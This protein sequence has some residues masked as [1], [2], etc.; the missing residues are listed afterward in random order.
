MSS[1]TEAAEKDRLAKTR[2]IRLLQFVAMVKS[3]ISKRGQHPKPHGVVRAS[4]EVLD[5]IP[6]RYKVG[7]FAKP[8]R[9]DAL[10][11]FS[12]GPQTE[13]REAGPQGMAIKLIGVPGEKI[14]EA[15][16]TAATH[17][18]I[19]IDGP[20]FFVRDTD[21]YVRLF[22]ELVRNLGGKPKEWLA[23][24]E[25]AHP[26]DIAV[27]ENYHNR[28]VD[29]P[30]AR[31]FWS[32]VPYAFGR[33]DTT[34]C[35]YQAVPDPQNMAAPIPPQYRDK[36]YLRRAM[37]DQLTTSARSASFDFFVQL[38]TDATPEVID[39]PTVEWDTPVQRVATIT[40]P[41]QD[42]DRP[43]QVRFGENLSYTPWHALPEH[44]PVGQ[45]NEIRRT[46]YAATSRLR[47][48]LNLARRKEPASAVPPPDPGR[49]LWRWARLAT[50][51]AVVAGLMIF[52]PKIWSMLHVAVPDFPPVEK[53]V[54]LKQN[55]EPPAREWYRHANQ[56]GQ[57][58]P[59]INVPY[60]WFMALEQPYLTLGDSG[61]LADQAYLDRF[62]FIRRARRR[63]PT[64]G[65]T[66]RSP[67]RDRT[68][69]AARPC[70]PGGIACRWASPAPTAKPIR[71]SCRT[72][73]HGAI[74]RPARP[75]VPSG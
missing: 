8:A 34:I 41:A 5:N 59:M 38:R 65:G 15:E 7:L 48:F 37:V 63:A 32:Q 71:C 24:L 57:F 26:E 21:W 50:A 20:V 17:D 31:P 46:V 52:V 1:E 13:D 54:W 4:F 49:P 35:R 12:N 42:F 55:W 60:E 33:G 18:F 14:L 22:K 67:R 29:S 69:P 44:R 70:R 47:H 30:L 66:A 53:S 64:T 25:K 9:Y 51:A 40:I 43:D 10:I 68:T 72:A 28:I 61:A 58:P 36:D 3:G 23:A 27:V 2:L 6:T 45:I 75:W 56:G 73:G 19:L 62:G 74:R 16:A 11:R 39:N